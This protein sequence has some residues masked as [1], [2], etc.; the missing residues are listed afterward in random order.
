MAHTRGIVN[1]HVF[2]ELTGCTRT[3]MFEMAQILAVAIDLLSG[4]GDAMD[5]QV[6]IL[7][8]L[9]VRAM[10]NS[11]PENDTANLAT[12]AEGIK[13]LVASGRKVQQEIKNGRN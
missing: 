10:L 4:G 12:V 3:D 7:T 11:K 8:L 2:E 9:L 1:E 6:S 5:V 13:R